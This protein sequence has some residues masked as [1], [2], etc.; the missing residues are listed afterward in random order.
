M[1]TFAMLMFCV[2]TGF[3]FSNQ[4]RESNVNGEKQGYQGMG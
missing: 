3:A 1:F 2:M 4:M